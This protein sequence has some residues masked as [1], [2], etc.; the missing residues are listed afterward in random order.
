LLVITLYAPSFD[1]VI[2]KRLN[3]FVFNC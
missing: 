1:F 2:F 3:E